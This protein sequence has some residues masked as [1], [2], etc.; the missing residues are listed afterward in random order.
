MKTRILSEIITEIPLETKIKVSTEFA[1]IDLIHVLGFREE[2]P[3]G[4]EENEMLNKI[5]EFAEK[6]SKH[7]IEIIKEDA[8][9]R[10]NKRI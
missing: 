2:K 3:W 7:I 1:F 5:L 9:S 4:K 10:T 8:N 6:H